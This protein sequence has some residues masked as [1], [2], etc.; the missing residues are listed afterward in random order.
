MIMTDMCAGFCKKDN[1]NDN[2]KMHTALYQR[3]IK[4]E[5]LC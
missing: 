4:A 5:K 1:D 3:D 2:V